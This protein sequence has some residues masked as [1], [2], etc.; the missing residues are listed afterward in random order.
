MAS[1]YW[2]ACSLGAHEEAAVA[3]DGDDLSVR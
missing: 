3:G 2:T 1:A